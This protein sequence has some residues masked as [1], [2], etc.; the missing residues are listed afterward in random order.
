MLRSLFLDMNAFFA[1]AEQHRHPRY[2]GRP[3][4]VAPLNTDATSCVAVSYEARVCGIRTGT[5]VGEA[6]RLCPRLIV[7]PSQTE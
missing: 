2:R 3:L 6:R 1:S 4:A 7:V 5:N